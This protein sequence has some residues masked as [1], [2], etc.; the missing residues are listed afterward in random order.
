MA[1]HRL[2]VFENTVL[3]DIL[4]PKGDNI[5]GTGK[6]YIRRSFMSCIARQILFGR[7]NQEE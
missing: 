4:V 3:R 2:K 6:D 1:V 5:K 7:S